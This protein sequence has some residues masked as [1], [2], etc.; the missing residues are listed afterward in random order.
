MRA[1]TALLLLMLTVA[2]IAGC[3]AR[4]FYEGIHQQQA[5]RNPPP[6]GQ[7]AP[8]KPSYEEYEAERRKQTAPVER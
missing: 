3:S 8:S 1:A 6:T 4:G 5:I 7:P 2:G